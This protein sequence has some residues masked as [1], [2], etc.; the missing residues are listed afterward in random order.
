MNKVL[1][2]VVLYL[3]LFCKGFMEIYIYVTS[4]LP[5]LNYSLMFIKKCMLFSWQSWTRR[6]ASGQWWLVEVLQSF[7]ATPSVTWEE[8]RSWLTMESTVAHPQSSRL[9]STPRLSSPSWHRRSIPRER[10]VSHCALR[11]IPYKP[12]RLLAQ[13]C[14]SNSV[15]SRIELFLWNMKTFT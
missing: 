14:Y 8:R 12:Y 3:V 4:K 7:T 1:L 9:T 5:F 13:K 2:C 11:I 10:Y 6:V 15:C